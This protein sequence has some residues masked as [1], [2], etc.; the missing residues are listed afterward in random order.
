VFRL[1]EFNA[2]NLLEGFVSRYSNYRAN[3]C[4]PILSIGYEIG[5]AKKRPPAYKVTA[6][7][8]NSHTWRQTPVPHAS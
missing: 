5:V 7:C 4:I 8:P 6:H 2:V 3:E 1:V